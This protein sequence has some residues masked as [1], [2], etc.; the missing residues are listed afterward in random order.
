MVILTV[1]KL[2]SVA[3]TTGLALGHIR[4][5][6]PATLIQIASQSSMGSAAKEHVNEESV[7]F[8]MTAKMIKCAKMDTVLIATVA[9]LGARNTYAT[10]GKPTETVR[11]FAL[12]NMD[13]ANTF[14]PNAP[15]AKP[16]MIASALTL[17]F[18]RMDSARR[19][20]AI[21]TTTAKGRKYVNMACASLVN[22]IQINSHTCAMIKSTTA[23][24]PMTVDAGTDNVHTRTR[25]APTVKPI[26]IAQLLI[27]VSA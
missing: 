19:E 15:P 26:G 23:E 27:K 11:T 12:A 22:A 17:V 24:R 3:L 21:T 16:T 7:A 20:N 9:R 2:W 14:T 10:T 13:V 6:L 5:A 1:E 8:I 18:V 4:P 25:I